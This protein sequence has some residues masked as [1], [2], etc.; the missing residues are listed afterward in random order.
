MTNATL[1][2]PAPSQVEPDVT[3]VTTPTELTD[4][5]WMGSL[6]RPALIAVVSV[7]LVLA[8]VAFIRRLIPDLPPVYTEL[9]AFVGATAAV[10]GCFTTTW[11]AQPGQRSKR[12][13]GYRA[14]EI[15]L[16]LGT[17]RIAI[18]L[19]TD[20]FPGLEQFLLRPVDSLLDGYF[21][22]GILV[23]GLAWFMATAMTE[24]LLAMALQPDDL[25]TIRTFGDRWQDTARPVYVD[26]PA[27]LRRFVARWVIG[28]ILLV[29]LAAGSR[30]DLPESGFLGVIRQNIDPT[31]VTAIILYFLAGLVLISQGQLALLRARWTLQK[32]P[33]TPSIRRNWPIYALIIIVLIGVVAALLPLGGTFYL[34][35]ILSAILSTLYM[36]FFGIFRFILSLF[37]ILMAWLSGEEAEA[38]PP[39]PPTPEPAQV[40]TPPPESAALLPPWTGGVFFWA[41]AALLLGYAAYIYFSGKGTDWLWARR[42][43]A[44]L[45]ARWLVLFGAYQSWQAARVRAEVE[46]AAAALRGEGGGR[47]D[48]LRLRNLDP[49]RQVRYYYLALL[50]RAN[51]AGIPRQEAETP[52]HYAPRLAENAAL[53]EPSREAIQELTDAFVEVRYAGGHVEKDRLAHLKAVWRQLKGYFKL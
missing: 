23:I 33:S 21:L 47:L 48:W 19:T 5:F 43:W 16:V 24:D 3:P 12:S 38:P 45:R 17:L 30:Y 34:A 10:V 29:L 15:T 39:P 9:L 6:L 49:D 28:G 31:V 2:P 20:S 52:L 13:M 41:F 53:D 22:V 35:Q 36:L 11:L 44:M 27:I 7:S 4:Q 18:W 8:L 46:R 42:L 26:R 32:T 1:P 37:L 50:Q 14:A 40:F 51:E 25:Y